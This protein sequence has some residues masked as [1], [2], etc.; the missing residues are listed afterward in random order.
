[1]KKR[2][3]DKFYRCSKYI[4]WL[5]Q[6]QDIQIIYSTGIGTFQLCPWAL[7]HG[8]ATIDERFQQSKMDESAGK[9]LQLSN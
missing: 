9:E 4:F 3:L 1:M 7:F 2:E 5:A 6:T 8:N